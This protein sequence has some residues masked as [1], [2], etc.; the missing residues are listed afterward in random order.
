MYV[1]K[2]VVAVVLV[3]IFGLYMPSVGVIV[4]AKVVHHRGVA[5]GAYL[6]CTE[7]DV[8]TLGQEELCLGREVDRLGPIVLLVGQSGAVEQSRFKYNGIGSFK[9]IAQGGAYVAHVAHLL[10]NE[11]A[12]GKILLMGRAVGVDGKRHAELAYCEVEPFD[13]SDAGVGV[14]HFYGAL[15]REVNFRLVGHL[16]Q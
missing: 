7:R 12:V 11:R 13:R 9:G 3:E 14:E 2:E 1:V 4:C 15:V 8:E 10:G 5:L 6:L 16:L